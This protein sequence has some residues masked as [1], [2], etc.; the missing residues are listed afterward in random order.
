[1]VV[2]FSWHKL[3]VWMGVSENMYPKFDG[4]PVYHSFS[5]C[6]LGVAMYT[7]HFGHLTLTYLSL[8]PGWHHG[9]GWQYGGGGTAGALWFKVQGSRPWKLLL[10][11]WSM[12]IDGFPNRKNGAMLRAETAN[13]IRGLCEA[14]RKA[15]MKGF[16]DAHVINV[17]SLFKFHTYRMYIH[18]HTYI[19]IYIQYIGT[20]VSVDIYIYIYIYI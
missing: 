2:F 4:L 13:Y 10:S 1:M 17:P 15:I 11:L 16:S 18:N 19:I 3:R 6:H 14:K 8:L 12:W 5:Y 7:S 20:Y 9:C